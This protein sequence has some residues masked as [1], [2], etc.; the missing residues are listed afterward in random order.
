M[1]SHINEWL[2]SYYDGEL[3]GSQLKQVEDHLAICPDCQAELDRY[4]DLSTL[5]EEYPSAEPI[6]SP[7]RFAAQVGLQLP[8]KPIEPAW[9]GLM[10]AGWQATPLFLFLTWASIQALFIVS[11]LLNWALFFGAGGEL[12]NTLPSLGQSSLFSSFSLNIALSAFLGILYVSWIASW[13]ARRV[14][15]GSGDQT[16]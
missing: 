14:Y 12:I 9:R 15:K 5:L 3:S 2:P 16:E 8:R 4:R 10:R 1:N 7:A 13:Y 6:S 11:G